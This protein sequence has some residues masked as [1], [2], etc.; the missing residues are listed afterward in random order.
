MQQNKNIFLE[1]RTT[2]LYY[3]FFSFFITIFLISRQSLAV[4][5]VFNI[6]D[7]II[8]LLSVLL[9]PKNNLNNWNYLTFIFLLIY[10]ILA[11]IKGTH[12][13]SPT[14]FLKIYLVFVFF[15]QYRF[16]N[17]EIIG[18]LNKTYLVYALISLFIFKFLP[19]TF[20]T[21]ADHEL[22]YVDLGFVKYLVLHSVEGGASTID[23]YSALIFLSNIFLIRDKKRIHY[24][25]IF[26]SLLLIIY[27]LKMTPLVALVA[28]LVSFFIIRN[29]YISII[30]MLIMITIFIIVLRLLFTNPEVYGPIRFSTI[31]YVATH[32]RSMIWVQQLIIFMESYHFVDYIFGNFTSESFTVNAYQ[33][34]GSEI[35]T[36]YDNPHNTYLL[37]FFKSPF[38]LIIYYLRYLIL[39]FKQFNRR[40]FVI[41]SFIAVA[42][43]SNSSLISLGNPVYIIIL[44]FL[45]TSPEYQSINVSK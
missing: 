10:S 21:V 4:Q 5:Y 39:I 22:N 25:F 30:Y 42:C 20:Y 43:F 34:S 38:L 15:K 40:S 32:A 8:L 16:K 11:I 36:N 45:L 26:F 29:K 6:L 18:F 33:L 28:A 35:T 14:L 23:S 9:L 3:L 37:L 24:F 41:I 7:I 44:A 19:S 17:E 2:I 27:S 12:I 31:M 13:N 1:Y